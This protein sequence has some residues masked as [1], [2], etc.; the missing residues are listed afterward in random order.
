MKTYIA[1]ADCTP[2][3]ELSSLDRS[4]ASRRSHLYF[5]EEGKIQNVHI[6]ALCS[7]V[8]IMTHEEL[9][10]NQSRF[11]HRVLSLFDPICLFLD[12]N[13]FVLN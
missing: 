12:F 6:H 3:H 4:T 10:A 9:E 13:F 11:S 7:L 5:S 8:P 2:G 1:Q